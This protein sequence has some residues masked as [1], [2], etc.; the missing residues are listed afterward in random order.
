VT[1][2]VQIAVVGTVEDAEELRT[3]LTSAGIDSET[4]PAVE[5]DPSS[6]AEV[7]QKV[8][9]AESDVEAA[10]EAV[11]ALTEPDELAAD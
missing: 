6:P 3:I 10:L 8:L 2:M 5:H 9:V 7:P 1:E 11:E 4:A